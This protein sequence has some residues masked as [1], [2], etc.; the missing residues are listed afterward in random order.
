MI[1]I[2]HISI[3][4][5]TAEIDSASHLRMARLSNCRDC[6]LVAKHRTAQP[7][8]IDIQTMGIVRTDGLASQAYRQP[9]APYTYIR[10]MS[11]QT[12]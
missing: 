11:S 7:S 2:Y 8:T 5:S 3:T 6:L 9:I 12:R 10:A 1:V 4:G